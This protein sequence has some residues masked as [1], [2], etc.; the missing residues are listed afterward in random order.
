MAASKPLTLRP[1]ILVIDDDD[2]IRTLLQRYLSEQGF[3]VASAGRAEE[4]RASMEAFAFDLLI[5]D[6]MMPDESGLDFI[7]SLRRSAE[8]IL[9]STP[10]IL[11]TAR[12][13]PKDR[14]EGFE[15]GADDYL[16]KPFE[17]RELLL[18]INAV[19]RRIP[20]TPEAKSTIKLGR[21]TY[22]LARDVLL[23]DTEIVRLTGMEAG[24]MRVLANEAG[25]PLTREKLA[26]TA[27]AD[28]GA[29][30]DRT[31]DVQVARLRRKIE[32]DVK[33]PRYLVTVRGEGYM[34]LPDMMS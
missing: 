21:W 33:N 23:S 16:S 32:D 13:D 10:V 26:E 34:L 14:I 28:K 2:R 11:L 22:D 1:H 25:S 17:P 4:A 3:V 7:A 15:L 6:V 8:P 31:V 24:L 18:R 19:L 12:G 9:R 5:L 29:I 20:K 30:Y 27:R